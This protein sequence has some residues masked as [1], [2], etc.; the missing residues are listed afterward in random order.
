MEKRWKDSRGDIREAENSLV[1]RVFAGRDT[2]ASRGNE[3][4]YKAQPMLDADGCS[5]RPLESRGGWWR[6]C[7][8]FVFMQRAK[9]VQK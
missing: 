5:R 3:V 9:P 6:T 4:M 2:A 7:D 8:G 1:C